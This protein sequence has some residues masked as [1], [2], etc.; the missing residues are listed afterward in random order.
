MVEELQE[1]LKLQA[2]SVADLPLSIPFEVTDSSM[3]PEDF[4]LEGEGEIK[5]TTLSIGLMKVGTVLR[6][7]PLIGKIHVKDLEKISV[8]PERPFDES[9]PEVMGRYTETIVEIICTGLH[10]KKGEYPDYMPEFI[11]ENCAWRDMHI[12]LNAITFRM[13]TLAFTNS[14]TML[15][16]VGP[17]AE[18]M[19]A[20][21]KNLKSWEK[22]KEN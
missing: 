16:K 12:L 15:M 1:I 18:E 8:T 2:E 9:A 19:I 6:I 7:H 13:G 4:P 21:Q 14:T 11:K 22:E 20:L 5:S 10:N 3:L 17:G